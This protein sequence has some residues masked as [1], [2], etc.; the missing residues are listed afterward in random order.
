MILIRQFRRFSA[1]VLAA[2]V[3]WGTAQAE[4]MNILL[5]GTDAAREGENARS[6]AMLLVQADPEENTLR[7]VSFLRDLYVSIPGVGETR[8]NAAYQHGGE[9]LLC[10]TLLQNFGT[11]IHRTVT[12]DFALLA[13]VVDQ[14]G[15]VELDLTEQELRHLN[16]LLK[17]QREAPL[18]Q[19]GLQR[20]NGRQALCY[21]RIRKLDS[22][23]Q[24]TQRQQTLIGAM[25]AQASTLDFW[26]LLKLA[27]AN[28]PRV[29]TDLT[30]GD[31][32]ALL[33]LAA[34]FGQMELESAQVP[35]QGAYREETIRGMMVLVPD[36]SACRR[37]LEA[38]LHE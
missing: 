19:A 14:L 2:M 1:L 3:L 34:R 31:I 4:A 15:G 30:L 5:I 8:L 7:M 22:D 17:D 12:V 24:R 36:L 29:R 25:L 9:K 6:D 27:S 26:S 33:P 10:D 28:L 38:F 11:P 35:F 13:D 16:A 23:F 37:Q 21:S 32:A 18:N 20:L